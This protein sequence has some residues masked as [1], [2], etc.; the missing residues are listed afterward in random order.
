MDPQI[1]NFSELEKLIRENPKQADVQAFEWQQFLKN[2]AG[3]SPELL[4]IDTTEEFYRWADEHPEKNIDRSVWVGKEIADSYY[5]LRDRYED[6]QMRTDGKVDASKIPTDLLGLP[7][8]AAGFLEKT[9]TMEDD[10]DYQKIEENL[11]KEW[12]KNNPGKDFL[13]KE[14]I[15]YLY[16]SLEDPT[17]QSLAKDSEASFRNNPKLKKRIER[18]DKEKKKIY[19]DPKDDPSPR[20]HESITQAHINTRLEYL[21]THDE[22]KTSEEIVNLVRKNSQEDFATKFPEKAK[23]YGQKVEGLQSAQEKIQINE[24][25]ASYTA[26][27]GKE[28]KYVEK[29]RAEPPSISVS[30]ATK[31]LE[32][33]SQPQEES[34]SLRTPSS[35]TSQISPP[36]QSPTGGIGRGINAVN[37]LTGQE[38]GNPLEKIG[39]KLA[40]QAV[41][42]GITSFLGATAGVWI[43]VVIAIVSV[44]VFTFIVVGFGGVP[45]SEPNGQTT[46][47]NPTETITPTNVA[48]QTPTP[49]QTEP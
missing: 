16:G 8:L 22:E 48:T 23:A 25:L 5:Y 41:T 17:K 12:L 37:K 26:S 19:K 32:G 49:T 40:Q 9:K 36:T 29:E 38:L 46:N 47:V 20:T 39:S 44:L 4:S 7:L 30:N 10:K 21:K 33:I 28:I 34:F 45:S 35:T 1:R 11:K 42:K 2:N 3:N 18:Y 27:S 31:I 13:S 15:D 43:P 24:A 6:E 14:G